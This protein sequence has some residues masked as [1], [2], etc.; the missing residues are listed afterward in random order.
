MAHLLPVSQLAHHS[1]GTEPFTDL[2]VIQAVQGA[3]SVHT[4]RVQYKLAPPNAQLG[5][6]YLPALGWSA[7]PKLTFV[8][9]FSDLNRARYA[10]AWLPAN[11]VFDQ[12]SINLEFRILH[13]MAAHSVI[14]NGTLTNVALNHWQISFLARSSAVSPMLEVHPADTL[15]KQTD[16]TVLPVSGKSITIEAWKPV[17][18]LENLTTQINNIKSFLAENENDYGGVLKSGGGNG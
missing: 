9:G 2:R 3:G 1:F 10:E 18:S 13:T 11:L 15:A 6:S 5:G 7:G 14:T 8:F 17:A 12:F 4:L 16:T